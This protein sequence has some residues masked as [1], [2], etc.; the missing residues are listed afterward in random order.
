MKTK[1]III[2]AIIFLLSARYI[3][4]FTDDFNATIEEESLTQT[5]NPGKTYYLS[6]QLEGTSPSQT[7]YPVAFSISSTDTYSTS[8][9]W[10]VFPSSSIII[11]NTG[12]TSLPFSFTVPSD[13]PAGE[14]T[15]AIGI[16]DILYV[17]GQSSNPPVTI[18]IPITVQVTKEALEPTSRAAATTTQS[19]SSEN[20]ISSTPATTRKVTFPTQKAPFKEVTDL[21]SKIELISLSSDYS[22]WHQTRTFMT[23]LENT[24]NISAF[25]VGSINI[26][27]LSNKPISTISLNQ[28]GAAIKPLGR[29]T[30]SSK[31]HSPNHLL[32]IFKA[33]LLLGESN[34]FTDKNTVPVQ[35]IYYYLHI[36]SQPLLVI[37]IATVF[38]LSVT[39]SSKKKSKHRKPLTITLLALLVSV[40]ILGYDLYLS[41]NLSQNPLGV[42]ESISATAQVKEVIGLRSKILP[43]Q[44]KAI[45]FSSTNPLGSTLWSLKKNTR[46]NIADIAQYTE[47]FFEVI[48]NPTLEE[49]PILMLPNGF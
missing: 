15:K 9:T 44:E 35:S 43:G 36:G 29:E 34:S 37:I 40:G 21:F 4:A 26:S 23:R 1:F 32:G 24:G 31:Y 45:Y 11:T 7:V 10:I 20:G 6:I 18:A 19:P 46:T 28:E 16:S 27:T 22:H 14:Y 25:P 5:A 30:L 47:P 8:D 2:F 41:E 39:R 3:S 13:T 49:Y 17:D 42:E 33:Q 12:L 38:L 48:L